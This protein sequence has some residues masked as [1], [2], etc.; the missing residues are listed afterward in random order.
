M[1]TIQSAVEID[2]VAQRRNSIGTTIT[3]AVANAMASATPETTVVDTANPIS[4][5]QELQNLRQII[6]TWRELEGEVS[7][8][9]A[10]VREKNKRKKALE[11]MIL[12]IMK[13]YNIGALDLKSGGRL[14][15]RKQTTKAALNP[16]A[17]TGLLSTHL[18]SETAAAE[19][20]KY[21][22]EHREARPRES[23]LYE[24]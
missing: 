17:L 23:I 20:I 16:K 24:K 1:S 19:A 7:V 8:L 21:I 15:H 2:I 14:L 18:K 4:E 13:K 12:R 10:Q 3:Q 22:N 6:V 5:Q 9:S 11:E